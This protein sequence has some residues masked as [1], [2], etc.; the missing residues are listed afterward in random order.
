MRTFERPVFMEERCEGSIFEMLWK[1]QVLIIC[2]SIDRW[3][4]ANLLDADSVFL[5]FSRSVFF[6]CKDVKWKTLILR[7]PVVHPP[8]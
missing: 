5:F 6:V 4:F 1:E 8:R 3:G 7:N 2:Y